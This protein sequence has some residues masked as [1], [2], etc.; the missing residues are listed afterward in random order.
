MAISVLSSAEG[1]GSAGATTGA[2][3]STGANFAVVGITGAGL[4]ATPSDNKSS[5]Y[6]NRTLEAPGVTIECRLSYSLIAGT[7]AD[8]TVT[9]SEASSF[10]TVLALFASGLHATTPYDTESAGAFVAPGTSLQP[11][12]LTPANAGSL[13]VAVLV[14]DDAITDL[15]IDSGFTILNPGTVPFAGGT[16]YGGAIAY[17]VQGAA[18]A[19][20]PTWSW[21]N[22][23]TGVAA[24]AAFAPAAAASSGAGVNR[25]LVNGGTN[26]GINGGL[27]RRSMETARKVGSLWLPGDN[28]IIRPRYVPGFSF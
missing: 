24:M 15:A 19:V 21:T 22:S 11:G 1:A 28:R 18:A 14:H 7:G 6:T 23:V 17:L 26:G 25:G 4:S 13:I 27:I 5:T 10:S 12:S 9:F 16:N 8:H 3:D 20:N 2:A